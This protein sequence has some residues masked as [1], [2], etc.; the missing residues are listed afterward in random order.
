MSNTFLVIN[1]FV[2][3]VMCFF[4]VITMHLILYHPNISLKVLLMIRLK[5]SLTKCIN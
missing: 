4:F 2:F 3:L 5:I 1:F